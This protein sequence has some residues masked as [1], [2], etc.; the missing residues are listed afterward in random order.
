MAESRF[1][2]LRNALH[3][4]V[5]AREHAFSCKRV[6]SNSQWTMAVVA[7]SEEIAVEA[8]AMAD[9]AIEAYWGRHQLPILLSQIGKRLA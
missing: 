7:A 8:E 1:L 5:E 9:E 6:G 3:E 4:A 2:H